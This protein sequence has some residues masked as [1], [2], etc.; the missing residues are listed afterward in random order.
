[1]INRWMSSVTSLSHWPSTSVYNTVGVR[2][3]VARVCQRQRKLVVSNCSPVKNVGWL[4]TPEGGVDAVVNT[5][6]CPGLER[7]AKVDVDAESDDISPFHVHT[8]GQGSETDRRTDKSTG[9]V[10]VPS[11]MYVIYNVSPAKTAEPIVMRFGRLTGV[12]PLVNIAF[13]WFLR[14]SIRRR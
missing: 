2:H 7:Q 4:L 12:G 14:F 11:C 3:R 6:H 5:W 9:S 8:S 1:M 10:C 13:L